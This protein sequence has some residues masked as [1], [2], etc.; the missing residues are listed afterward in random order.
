M[1]DA[2]QVKVGGDLLPL[3]SL[4]K[5]LV[6]GANALQLTVYDGMN[7]KAICKAIEAADL[8]LMPEAIGKTVRV[9]VPR[10]TQ[11]I[12]NAL[13][14]QVKKAGEGC[15]TQIRGHR[16][17][18]IKTAKAHP[19]KEMIRRQEKDVQKLHDD[20]IAKVDAAVQAKEKD[21]TNL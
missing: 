4:A 10:A 17:K 5:V 14:K 12:R 7:T 18:A 1:L 13:A 19:S 16:Q 8:N 9:P 6:Q 3:P 20:F 2:V 11:E 21:V 15:R